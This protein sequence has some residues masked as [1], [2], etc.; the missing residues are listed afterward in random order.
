M[1]QVNIYENKKKKKKQEIE[2][3]RKSKENRKTKVTNKTFDILESEG[4]QKKGQWQL[5]YPSD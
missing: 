5:S 3:K 2:K 4:C 1:K